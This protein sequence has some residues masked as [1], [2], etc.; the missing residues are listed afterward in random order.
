MDSNSPLTPLKGSTPVVPNVPQVP[1]VQDVPE[2]PKTP[3]AE[4]PK[5]TGVSMPVGTNKKPESPTQR[6][7]KINAANE[8]KPVAVVPEQTLLHRP[9]TAE[10]VEAYRKK[11][12]KRKRRIAF[13][14][15]IFLI[16]AGIT[17]ATT[18]IVKNRQRYLE[19]STIYNENLPIVIYNSAS[20]NVILLSQNGEKI[21]DKY[22]NISTFESDRSLATTTQGEATNYTIIS[23]TGEE[24]FTTTDILRKINSGQNYILSNSTGSYLLDKD[25]KTIDTKGQEKIN[26]ILDKSEV[27]SFS[28]AQNAY[29]DNYYCAL[30][31]NRKND[32]RLYIY[33]CESGKEITN[34]EDVYYMGSFEKSSSSFLT[35]EKG[36]SYF[37]NNEMIYNSETQDTEYIGGIIKQSSDGKFFNPVTRKTTESFPTESLINQDELDEKT[38][39]TEECSAYE[40]HPESKL[41]NICSNIYYNNKLVVSS[42]SNLEYSLADKK[43]DDFLSFYKKYYF[44]RENKSNQKLSIMDAEIGNEAYNS[45]LN[46]NM[47]MN[48][49]DF[50]SRF[51]VRLNNQKKNVIDLATGE[52][53][54]YEAA[55][56]ISLSA[57]YYVVSSEDGVRY[58]NAKHKEIYKEEY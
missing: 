29:E 38:T 31:I 16:I 57:N 37:Y 1:K 34:I 13:S 22:N 2:I 27:T 42:T 11:I 36:S 55:V 18:L 24:I 15:L 12:S 47:N 19:L 35:S 7:N 5:I 44:N 56:N 33:N 14:I 32:S 49:Q 51:I 46:E 48:D 25:G 45:I 28:Y 50:A 17:T 6:S 54:E 52:S 26:G 10:E 40:N 30:I 4:P 8:P 21:T 23:N 3:T 39:V 20:E 53:A 9:V 43:L 58:Y 41:V